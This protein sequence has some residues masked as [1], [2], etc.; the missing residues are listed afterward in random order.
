MKIVEAEWNQHLESYMNV[1]SYTLSW[2]SVN[3]FSPMPRKKTGLGVI[4]CPSPLWGS[5]KI[6]EAEY[7]ALLQGKRKL[8]CCRREKQTEQ[9]IVR[10]FVFS[11]CV[12]WVYFIP[13]Y[14]KFHSNLINIE[15]DKA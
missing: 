10:K 15:K 1:L 9:D 12:S 13:L 14:S 6:Y 7:L 8:K 4:L 5:S 3:Y 11:S 2:A